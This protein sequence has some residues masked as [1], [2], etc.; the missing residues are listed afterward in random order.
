MQTLKIIAMQFLAM[1]SQKT[2]GTA[3]EDN[4]IP[5]YFL[6]FVTTSVNLGTQL[7]II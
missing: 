6:T 5:Q 1:S 7:A 2:S 4:I 3:V